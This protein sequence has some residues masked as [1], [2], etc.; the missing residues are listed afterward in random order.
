M[1]GRYEE[2][3]NRI[4]CEAE[5]AC[6]ACQREPSKRLLRTADSRVTRALQRVLPDKGESLRTLL[7]ET[8]R[9]VT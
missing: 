1:V 3:T 7:T 4:Y 2:V 5:Q 8:A 6:F 9:M